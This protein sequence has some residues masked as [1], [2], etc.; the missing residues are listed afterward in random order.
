MVHRLRC[1]WP[2]KTDFVRARPGRREMF[3]F[4]QTTRGQPTY[5]IRYKASFARTRGATGTTANDACSSTIEI[6][7]C[8][9]EPSCSSFW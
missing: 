5:A 1:V 8:Q 9:S 2:P 7:L 4:A 6:M 3:N